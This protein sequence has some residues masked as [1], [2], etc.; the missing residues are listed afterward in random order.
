MAVPEIFCGTIQKTKIRPIF[1]QN[2]I[3]FNINIVIIVKQYIILLHCNK[4]MNIS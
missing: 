4:I 2:N 1:R 3:I